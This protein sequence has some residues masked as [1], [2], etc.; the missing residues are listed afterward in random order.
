MP[1]E[2][3]QAEERRCWS[4]IMSATLRFYYNHLYYLKLFQRFCAAGSAETILP[5]PTNPLRLLHR[6]LNGRAFKPK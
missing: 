4:L 3:M 6:R 1:V 5:A 2:R